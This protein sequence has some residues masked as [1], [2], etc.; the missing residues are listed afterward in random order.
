[1]L[2]IDAI[3]VAVRRG[4]TFEIREVDD[5]D[6]DAHRLVEVLARAGAGG[7]SPL[8]RRPE[9]LP[10]H[11][12]CGDEVV[13][14]VDLPHVDPRR[15]RRR[16]SQPDSPLS[17]IRLHVQLHAGDAVH[18]HPN[19]PPAVPELVQRADFSADL[20]EHRCFGEVPIA[21]V[22]A[23]AIAALGGCAVD[24]GAEGFSVHGLERMF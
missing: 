17:R 19:P 24:D 6:A 14:R 22:V 13:E 10:L 1:M 16:L 21:V 8:L 11:L 2:P 9:R 3:R 20:L 15:H 23:I 18:H 7:I 4:A 12:A 5:G